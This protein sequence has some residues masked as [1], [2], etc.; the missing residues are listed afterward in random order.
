MMLLAER[1]KLISLNRHLI[2]IFNG[3]RLTWSNHI[4]VIVGKVYSM[5]R[6]LWAVIYS[7]PFVIRMQL[8]KTFLI[9]VILWGYQIFEIFDTDD[10]RIS[11]FHNAAR[12]GRWDHMSQFSECIFEINFDNL[13]YIK[14]QILLHKIITLE[15]PIQ[16]FRRIRFARSKRGKKII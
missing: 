15:Q 3:G 8:A 16:L 5:L 10:R 4:N 13:L 12:Y 9:P 1:I 7:T 6:N 14:Y 2:V 11:T